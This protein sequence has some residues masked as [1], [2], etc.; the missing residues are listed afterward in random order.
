MNSLTKKLPLLL[1]ASHILLLLSCKD[2]FSDNDY[3]AFFGGE[4]IHPT[5][6]F[7]LLMKNGQ[8]VDTLFLDEKNKFLKKFDSLAPGL[9]T[10]K[11]EAEYQYV[12]FDK[13]DS[14]MVRINTRDFDESIVF[15]GRGEEKNNFLIDLYLKNLKDQRETFE[16]YDYEINRF[17]E[18]I[19]SSF[20]TR[21]KYYQSKK[22]EIAWSSKFDTYAKNALLLQHFTKKEVYP[23][24]HQMRKGVDVTQQLP[25]D[26]YSHRLEIDFN[27][28][29]LT[30]YSPFVRYLSHMLANVSFKKVNALDVPDSER[31]L[32]T[33]LIKLNIA[34]TL[35]KE[36]I[37]RDRV[38]NQIAF[39]FMLEDQNITRHKLFLER[40]YQLSSDPEKK[41]EIASLE[42]S[43]QRLS[44]GSALPNVVFETYDKKIVNSSDLMTGKSVILFWTEN[45][46]THL[47]A[48]HKKI[49]EYQLITKGYNYY[50]IN[51]D[52]SHDDW[53]SHLE[54]HRCKTLHYL[55]AKNFDDLKKEWAI[56][57]LHRTMILDKKG[58]IDHA[59]VNLF[60]ANFAT[61]LN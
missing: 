46:E 27:D 49:Q 56:I 26:Y 43:I 13:N 40:Y 44:K 41:A 51:I 21:Y 32:Q 20:D 7:V 19:D 5:G 14:L 52:T 31:A 54:K 15:S 34:D 60:D 57:K 58:M 36:A 35:F 47:R 22:N 42:K 29:Y 59:F 4:I 28:P 55:K 18:F 1:I 12:Y 6:A 17:V 50:V 48:I 9:Y 8:V 24:M 37:V 61:Y 16:A 10:F 23:I 3:S 11:H 2:K 39:T 45:A 30:F 53:R 38:L 33:G 25:K